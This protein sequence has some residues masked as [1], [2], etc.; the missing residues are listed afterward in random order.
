[1]SLTR[2]Q[3]YSKGYRGFESL[4]LRQLNQVFTRLRPA[5]SRCPSDR[6]GSTPEAAQRGRAAKVPPGA[7]ALRYAAS[8]AG[9]VFEGRHKVLVPN[10]SFAIERNP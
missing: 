8:A 7:H 5:R 9:A 6:S 4:P 1:M 10:N 3:V 2:N